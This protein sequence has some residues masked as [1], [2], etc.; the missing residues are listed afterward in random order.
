[1]LPAER[2]EVTH[3]HDLLVLRVEVGRGAEAWVHFVGLHDLHPS[4]CVFQ[5]LVLIVYLLSFLPDGCL[6]LSVVQVC[7]LQLLLQ[8]ENFLLKSLLS[9]PGNQMVRSAKRKRK[10]VY[11]LGLNLLLDSTG[12]I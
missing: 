11:L 1:M 10:S 6:L 12:Y 8:G 2:L 7:R 5:D 3:A 4:Q 9:T